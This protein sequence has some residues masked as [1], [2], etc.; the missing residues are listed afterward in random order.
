MISIEYLNLAMVR[1]VAEAPI[2]MG[3]YWVGGLIAA[4]LACIA[5]LLCFAICIQPLVRTAQST[6]QK[7]DA[8]DADEV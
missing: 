6:P 8:V 1:L 4:M 2:S 5:G 3:L 7:Y